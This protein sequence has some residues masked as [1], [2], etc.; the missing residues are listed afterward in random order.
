[1]NFVPGTFLDRETCGDSETAKTKVIRT[2]DELEIGQKGAVV[3]LN[4]KGKIRRR[5][6]D[7]G[8]VKNVVVE[9]VN[10]APLNDPIDI[11]VKGFDLALRRDEAALIEVEITE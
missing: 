4:T 5:L 8:V 7:L 11:K 6:Q 2:L 3:T 10:T 1:M 9:V